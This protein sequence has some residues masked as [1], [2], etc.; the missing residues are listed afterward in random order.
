VCACSV[1][2]C[3]ARK[4]EEK[5][6]TFST[7]SGLGC[8][9]LP[10]CRSQ[11][12]VRRCVAH[13]WAARTCDG[14]ATPPSPPRSRCRPCGGSLRSQGRRSGAALDLQHWSAEVWRPTHVRREGHDGDAGHIAAVRRWVAATP[15]LRC[16]VSRITLGA[17]GRPMWGQ[18]PGRR[19][20]CGE[21]RIRCDTPALLHCQPDHSWGRWKA[22]ATWCGPVW[23][24]RPGRRQGCGEALSRSRTPSLQADGRHA[25]GAQRSQSKKTVAHTSALRTCAKWRSCDPLASLQGQP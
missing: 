14:R 7:G 13:V 17:V 1:A 10:L 24:Q 12:A 21:A 15:L 23:G 8:F 20:G 19:H 16:R 18:R 25:S 9:S 3:C 5:P 2:V 22:D 4:T 11:Q 6:L